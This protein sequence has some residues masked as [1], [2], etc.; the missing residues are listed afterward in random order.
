[1][2]GVVCSG[3]VFLA[4]VVKVW[5]GMLWYGMG[6]YGVVCCAIVCCGMVWCAHMWYAD[7][8]RRGNELRQ[9]A[10]TA[11]ENIAHFALSGAH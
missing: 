3:V 1:M 8:A 10:A 2:G 9:R 11:S 5:C 6:W 7:A 4:G